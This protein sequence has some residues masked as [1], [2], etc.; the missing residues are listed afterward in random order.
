MH[1]IS[2]KSD[3]KCCQDYLSEQLKKQLPSTSF[4]TVGFQGGNEEGEARHN[5][6]LWY[7]ENGVIVK[8]R[9]WNAFGL[10]PKKIKTT[11]S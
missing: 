4:I 5:D 7:M 11:I 10:N 3:I 2:K 9:Y 1:T 8:N 6:D